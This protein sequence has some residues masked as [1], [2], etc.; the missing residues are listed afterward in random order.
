MLQSFGLPLYLLILLICRQGTGILRFRSMI[1]IYKAKVLSFN[2]HA[3][4]R[5]HADS[6][7]NGKRL[8]PKN[9][10]RNL[11]LS[12][13]MNSSTYVPCNAGVCC[14]PYIGNAAMLFLDFAMHPN[15]PR[16]F[17]SFNIK[18]YTSIFLDP[19]LLTI[20]LQ[21][22]ASPSLQPDRTTRVPDSVPQPKTQIH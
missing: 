11:Q 3:S 8:I 14:S 7:F 17:L 21:I 9:A 16:R 10:S 12:L 19:V 13:Q 6:L 2:E 4:K 15:M 22:S 5:Y 18:S 1:C 20:Q